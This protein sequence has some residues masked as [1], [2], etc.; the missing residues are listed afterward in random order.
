MN[1]ATEIH[2]DAFPAVGPPPLPMLVSL[3]AGIA[4]ICLA[5]MGV[6][7][8]LEVLLRQGFNTSLLVADEL[9]TYLLLGTTFLGF[10]V[11]FAQER[12]FRMEELVGK[13]KGRPRVA[14][15]IALSAVAG[16]A[17]LVIAG[18][19]ANY[20]YDSWRRDLL[21]DTMLE[22]PLWIPQTVMF[23]GGALLTGVAVWRLL[24]WSRR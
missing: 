10:G 13:L 8:V 1:R 14:C 5:A 11:A 7:I 17:M 19:L 21:S 2:D 12:L 3:A 24:R 16:L 18:G 15:E 4:D 9:S 23:I 20:A 6:V 22:V